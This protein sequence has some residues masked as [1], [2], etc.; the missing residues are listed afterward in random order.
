MTVI[1][2]IR[3]TVLLTDAMVASYVEAQQI[4]ITRDFAPAW[5]IDAE[6]VFIAPGGAI[7]SDAWQVWFKDHT[8]QDGALGYHDVIGNPISY[9][10]TADDF[11]DGLAWTVTAS[12]EVLE[13]LG[14]PDIKQVRDADGFEYAY[15]ACDA[16]EDDQFAYLIDGHLMSDFVLPSWFDPHGAAPFTFRNSIDGPL[17]LA[18][19]GYIGRRRLPD[20]QWEQLLA[21]ER[22]PRQSKR[23]TSRTMRRFQSDV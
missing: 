7:P 22:S 17:L 5:G 9:V 13:M 4:Q 16:C 23:T 6:C 8:D 18:E 19:G 14:D 21:A 15:E 11:D 10:F 20:G 12:H 2:F 1:A 3:D